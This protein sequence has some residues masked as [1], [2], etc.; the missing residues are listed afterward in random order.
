MRPRQQ[1]AGRLL[2]QH[3]VA[4]TG[5]DVEG[6]VRLAALELPDLDGAIETRQV[7]GEMS[8]QRHLVEAVP[9]EDRHHSGMPDMDYSAARTASPFAGLYFASSI[10]PSWKRCTSSG[11]STMRSV[12]AI[13]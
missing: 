6:R 1:L 4:G 9:V 11:P 5:C 10:R 13:L 12:R 2:A 8:R 7:G 3:V